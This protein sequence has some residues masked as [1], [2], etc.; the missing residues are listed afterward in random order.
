MDAAS[1]ISI[2]VPALN[3]AD[4]LE[5][6]VGIMVA[7][8][9]RAFEAYEILIFDDGSTDGTD[10]VADRLAAQ[11]ASIVAIHH[12]RPAGLGGVIRAGHQRARMRYVIW[13]DGKGATT[14]EALDRIFAL[15]GQADLIIPYPENIA[16]RS[17]FRLTFSRLFTRLVNGLFGL[18]LHYYNHLVMGEAARLRQVTVH[19]NSYAFQAE[20]LIKLLKSGCTYRE[21]G[22]RDDFRFEGRRTKAFK[23]RNILGVLRFFARTF[24]DVQVRGAAGPGPH[25]V[26]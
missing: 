22:V 23:L 1:S 21:V 13:I 2:I 16:E 18:Q 25:R 26:G 3:E 5:R 10:A 7:A 19:T 17:A 4:R 9:R 6:A 20:L 11:D 14:P 8:A 15:R 12:P 24:W